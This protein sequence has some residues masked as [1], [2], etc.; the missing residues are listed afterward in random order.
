[1]LVEKRVRDFSMLLDTEDKGMGGT[2]LA[3]QGWEGG[4][5]D[6]LAGIL[7]PDDVVIE[8]GA[9]LG[10]YAFLEAMTAKRVYAIE[11]DGRNVQI[12]RAAAVLNGFDNLS[13][14]HLAISGENGKALFRASPGRSDRGRLSDKGVEVQTVTLDTF[15]ES[16]GIERVDVVRCD[17][18][19]AEVGMIKA[20]AETLSGMAEGSWLYI[21]LHPAK[22]QENF[23][24]TV[25]RILK[26]GFKPRKAFNLARS[27]PFVKRVCSSS[28]PRVFFQKVG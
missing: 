8:M 21:D 9:C 13:V 22:V 16:E 23:A 3:D 5:P 20:G 11:A 19:G 27:G 1:M 18:E 28:F 15:V 6:Y 7:N 17:I 24:S 14:H 12:M 25:R 10:Y 4:A 26:Y 2:L